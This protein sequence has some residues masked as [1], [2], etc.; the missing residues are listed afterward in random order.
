MCE[1]RARTGARSGLARQFVPPCTSADAKRASCDAQGC[2]NVAEDT[3]PGMEEVGQRTERLPRMS[4]ATAAAAFVP[5][6]TSAD[7][8]RASMRGIGIR[9]SLYIK[10]RGG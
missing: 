6:C 10:K 3:T 8:E 7:A 2:A 4:G 5:P 1:C 9:T